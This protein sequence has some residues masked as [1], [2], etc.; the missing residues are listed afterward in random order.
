M[1]PFDEIAV[2]E[3][4][5]LKEAGTATEVIAVS[6]GVTQCQETCARAGHRRRPRH[7]GRR[8]TTNCQPLAVAKLLK[9]LVDEGA[10]RP[11]HP[12]QA[13]DRRRLQP[14]RPDAGR[15]AGLAAGHLR[16][17]GRGGRRQRATSPARSTAACETVK[18]QAA[19]RGHHRPAPERAALRHAAQHHEGEEEAARR[20]KTPADLGVDVD[21]APRRC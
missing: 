14:D 17:E 11:G 9:A 5:R 13:G 1:N 15:A 21:A 10:A 18:R 20:R 2:E 6:I 7:P 12:R 19:G 4:V 16:L 8:P 3:A